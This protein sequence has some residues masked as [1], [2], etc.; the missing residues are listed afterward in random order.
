MMNRHS[1]LLLWLNDERQQDILCLYYVLTRACFQ[2]SSLEA[3]GNAEASLV[4]SE[5]GF[6]IS[7]QGDSGDKPAPG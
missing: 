4:L 7:I 5:N 3:I 1:I 2:S 6:V